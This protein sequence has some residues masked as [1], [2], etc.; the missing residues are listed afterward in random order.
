MLASPGG[1]RA[2]RMAA[3]CG[4]RRGA[5]L[6]AV[7][8]RSASANSLFLAGMCASETCTEIGYPLLDY[9]EDAGE[10]VCRAHPCWDDNGLT[11]TCKSKPDFPFLAFRYSETKD[12]ICECSSIPHYSS[13]H[14]ARDLCAGHMCDK[15]EFPILD[16]DEEKQECLCRAHPCWD[17]NGQKHSCNK[18]EFPILKFRQDKVDGELKNVCECSISMEKG[19]GPVSIDHQG[20]PLRRDH[21]DEEDFLDDGEDDDF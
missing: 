21:A 8:A 14:I 17:D 6:L 5:L 7:L 1:R 11:H 18:A 16:Y 9:D 19:Q 2:T 13:V 3:T 15:P 10:C 4:W 20:Q 12:L